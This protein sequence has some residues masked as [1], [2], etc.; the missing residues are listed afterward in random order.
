MAKRFTAPLV[1]VAAGS[2]ANLTGAFPSEGALKPYQPEV[3]VR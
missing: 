3:A 1:T 2:L